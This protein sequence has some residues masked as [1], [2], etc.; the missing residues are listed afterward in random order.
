MLETAQREPWDGRKY[1]F[2]NIS[3]QDTYA[4]LIAD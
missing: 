2:S 4:P 1:M 3:P